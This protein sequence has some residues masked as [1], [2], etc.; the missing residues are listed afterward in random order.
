MIPF[1]IS[2]LEVHPG[3]PSQALPWIPLNIKIRN[4]IIHL[5]IAQEIIPTNLLRFSK[6]I[7]PGTPTEF[8][9]Q[10]FL[11]SVFPELLHNFPRSL[12][13]ILYF[14]DSY[15]IS[16]E[17]NFKYSY[18]KPP[19]IHAQIHSG[20]LSRMSLETSPNQQKIL[21]KKKLFL[22]FFQKLYNGY[23]KII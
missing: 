23:Y 16:S 4:H 9:F 2:S 15:K 8:F 5:R 17:D 7:Y 18:R 6:G 13:F 3:I 21:K 22:E 12:L 20:N 10:F 1:K 19:K 11:W 14:E